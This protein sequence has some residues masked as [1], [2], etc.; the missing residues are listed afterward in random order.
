[1]TIPSTVS[2]MDYVGNGVT[3]IYPYTFKIVDQTHLS[4]VKSVLGVETT[5][6]LTTDYAVS[7]VGAQSGGNVTLTAA[8]A[9]GALLIIRRVV[10][11]L[12][13]TDIKNQ[14]AF[15]P[16][17]HEDE[18]DSIVMM[19]QQQQEELDRAVKV[20]VSGGSTPESYLTDLSTFVTAFMAER[21]ATK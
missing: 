18:F 15:Y 5:L 3:T 13:P 21:A 6:V 10:P 7:G 14:G 16:E 8:L 1:M 9:S 17:I 19:V 4:V 2:R 12:Q 20:P 11:L